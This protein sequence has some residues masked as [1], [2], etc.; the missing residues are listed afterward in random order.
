MPLQRGV[1]RRRQ[2][3][4]AGD[5]AQGREVEPVCREFAVRRPAGIGR[6]L[7][8]LEI[9]AR[10]ALAFGRVEGQVLGGQLEGAAPELA[11]QPPR[12]CRE[13]QR[14]QCRR[15]TGHDVCQ[16]QVGGD[17]GHGRPAHLD[18]RAQ[19]T[20]AL[21]Q[22]HAQVSVPLQAGHID[23]REVGMDLPRPFTPAA[24]V[25]GQEGLL[26][27]GHAAEAVAPFRRRRGIEA[28]VVPPSLVAQ[29]QV[30]VAQGQ[31]GFAAH[32]VGPDHGAMADHEFGLREQTVQK[33][34]VGLRALGQVEPGHG[35]LAV[36]SAAHVE[37]RP[38]DIELVE[39]QRQHRARR[40]REEHPRQAQ[41]LASLAIE[42]AHVEQLERRQQAGG[43]GRDA[44]DAHRHP[45]RP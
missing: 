22:V 42:Q 7:H 45:Q 6:C 19:G 39:L 20:A 41:G 27:A 24:V 4:P 1:H 5:L 12:H 44:L 31:R 15:Q 23:P 17:C 11:R 30:D 28:Q 38:V 43:I 21:L 14:L 10:P 40:Q 35:P 25:H 13:L 32:L 18:P 2:R 29:H 33:P 16:G 36:G 34:V 8:Q 37:R 9:A 3:Q 26:E